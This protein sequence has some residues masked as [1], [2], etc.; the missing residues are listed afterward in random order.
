LLALAG[1]NET[2]KWSP[3]MPAARLSKVAKAGDR[4]GVLIF[5]SL[6]GLNSGYYCVYVLEETI[7]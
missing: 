6:Q 2:R 5:T 1:K 4:L 7:D 3:A